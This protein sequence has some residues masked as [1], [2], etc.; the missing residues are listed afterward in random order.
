MATSVLTPTEQATA[1]RVRWVD[2]EGDVQPSSHHES[3][4]SNLAE[5]ARNRACSVDDWFASYPCLLQSDLKGEGL[6]S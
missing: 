2:Q 6:N 4:Q 3:V 5:F 1:D